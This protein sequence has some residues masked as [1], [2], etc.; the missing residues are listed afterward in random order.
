MA[1]ILENK[2]EQLKAFDSWVDKYSDEL[3]GFAYSRLNDKEQAEDIIQETFISAWKSLSSYNPEVPAKTWIY[4]ILKN[5]II[6]YYRSKTYRHKKDML[7]AD[8]ESNYFDGRDMW[9]EVQK[10]KIWDNNVYS[11]IESKEFMQTLITCKGHLNETQEVVFTMKYLDD[12]ES[13]EICKELGIT[14]S[15]YWVLIHRAKLKIR[16]CLELLWFKK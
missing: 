10:P 6:D 4:T 7:S 16:K 2:D 13:E 5:K 9:N 1:Q 11:K 3:Y 15:N 8:Q 12:I 14:S